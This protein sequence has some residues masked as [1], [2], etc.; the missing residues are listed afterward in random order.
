LPLGATAPA[1]ELPAPDGPALAAEE[2]APRGEAAAEERPARSEPE[3]GAA[4]APAAPLSLAD[5]IRIGLERQPALAAHRASVAAAETQYRGLEDLR[6]PTF[7][8]RDLPI[9]RRQAHLGITIAR[10]GLEQ[11]QWETIY[12]I[13]RTYY[14]VL[15]ARQ[16]QRVAEDVVSNLK[17]YQERVSEL[18]KK[19][20]SREWTT[21]T[22]DKITVYLRLAQTRREEA[23]RGIERATAALREAMGIPPEMPLEIADAE[24]PAPKVE[25]SRE[26]IVALALARRGEL[27][28][29][30]TAERVVCL[31]IEAQDV[32]CGVKTQTFASVVDIH[33]RPVPQGIENREYR[34]G[35]MGLEVPP[36]F[37]GPRE[38]RVE[39]ARELD[40][41][42][43]AVVEKTRN[44]IAL[45]AADAHANWQEAHRRV[46]ETR[47]AAEAGTRLAKTTREDFTSGAQVRIE[48]I[49]TNEVLAGQARAASNEARYHELIGLASLQRVT[50]GGFDPGL[51]AVAQPAP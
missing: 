33:A 41:R 35:A 39:R 23:L 32:T 10:A 50:A 47:A 3:A 49:L 40:A 17:F 12:A 9:R 31:E 25:V 24:L 19:G 29:V 5:C 15:Y 42:A 16:Q 6:V 45:D 8:R 22:V 21:S 28:Q 18:V 37:A 36:H 44:L 26:D 27:V 2:R 38:A 13:T 30:T 1:Q 11:A 48:D 34:P 51:A 20:E 46:P 43:V 7:L 14:G 4:A